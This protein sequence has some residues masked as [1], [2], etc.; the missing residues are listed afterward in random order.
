MLSKKEIKDIQS[1]GHKKYR[2]ELGLFVAEGP[3]IIHEL[4]QLV[5]SMIEKI[6]AT[7]E[8]LNANEQGNNLIYELVDPSELARLSHLQTPNQVLAVVKQFDNREPVASG[9]FLYLDTIQDPGNLG[10]IIRIADWFNIQGIVCSSGCA[11]RYNP[12]VIQATMSSIARVSIYEDLD[13]TWLQKQK[14]PLFAATLNGNS[15]YGHAKIKEGILIIGNESKG[16]NKAILDQ[17]SEFITIP[18]KGEAESLNAAVA[19]GILMSH[20]IPQ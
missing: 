1:L 4:R 18:K 5:P 14:L 19:T 13:G 15:L 12:K 3:K 16:I 6:Y 2:D 9:F 20:L 17:A 10:S 11:D 8:W 7:A